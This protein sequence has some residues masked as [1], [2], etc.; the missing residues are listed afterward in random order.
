MLLP[1]MEQIEN[2]TPSQLVQL[3][4]DMDDYRKE[5]LRRAT[6]FHLTYR[7][8][9]DEMKCRIDVL[10]LELLLTE[11]DRMTDP[12]NYDHLCRVH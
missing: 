8:L 3:K 4:H 6:E 7:H 9:R 11:E 5:L 1:T 2:L 12:L 10:E